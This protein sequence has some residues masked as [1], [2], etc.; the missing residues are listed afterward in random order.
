MLIEMLVLGLVILVE[1]HF[2]LMVDLI[3]VILMNFL[4]VVIL[5]TC[6]SIDI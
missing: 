2:I 4:M 1:S 5:E 3:C 6:W